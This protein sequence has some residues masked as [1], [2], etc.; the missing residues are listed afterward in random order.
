MNVSGFEKWIPSSIQE[1]EIYEPNSTDELQKIASVD[2]PDN[3]IYDPDY[4]YLWVRIVSAGEYYGPNKNGDYFPEEQLI[5]YYHTFKNAHPFKNHENKKVENAIGQVLDVRWNA[6]MKCVEV[7][8]GID[9]KRAPEVVRGFLKGY[10]TDVSMGC[11]VPY[12]VCSVCGNKARKRSEFCQHVNNHRMQYLGTGERVFEINFEPSFHDSSVVL[13][14]AE[15]VAKALM[16]IDAPP[17]GS[18]V[19]FKK[20]AS[21]HSKSAKYVRLTEYEMEKVAAFKEQLH[22]FFK[23]RNLDKVAGEGIL[24]KLAELEKELTGKLLN[25]VSTPTEDEETAASNIIGIVRFLTEKRMDEDNISAISETLRNLADAEC[26]PVHRVFSTFLGIAELMGIELYPTE[27]HKILTNLTDAKL[28]PEMEI[29]KAKR[30]EISPRE[31]DRKQ[32]IIKNISDS[33]PKLSDPS[34]FFNLYDDGAHDTDELAHNPV[35]FIDSLHN[36]N[37][38]DFEPPTKVVKVIRIT[39]KPLLKSRSVF[40]QFSVPRISPFLEGLSPIIGNHQAAQDFDILT[41]PRSIGDLIAN[42]AFNSF[43]N[44]KSVMPM[45]KM[46]RIAKMFDNSFEKIAN[47]LDVVPYAKEVLASDT[48]LEQYKDIIR[49]A[50]EIPSGSFDVLNNEFLSSFANETNMPSEKVAA[51]KTATLMQFGGLEKEAREVLDFYDL[52]EQSTGYMLKR[53]SDYAKEEMS[54]IANDYLKNLII[55]STFNPLSIS[56]TIPGRLL[57]AYIFTKVGDLLKSKMGQSPQQPTYEER[58]G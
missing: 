22:P 9:K 45:T 23:P 44:M 15:R 8:K 2:L 40:P 53:A 49:H 13:S 52:S 7:F 37:D 5:E 55:D 57:D 11:R 12:T 46:I 54:K 24:Q 36:A 20:V 42:I 28:N 10:L 17:S 31:V 6:V 26:L 35:S 38:F 48:S 33:V 29:S 3:F 43:Q 47:E 32:V 21:G 34:E 58:R 18:S 39:L 16:I 14:G 1:Y 56:T 27:L 25:V 51:L 4:L 30:S 41:G 50:D 19:T